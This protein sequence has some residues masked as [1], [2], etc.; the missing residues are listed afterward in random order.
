MRGIR[1]VPLA[2]RLRGHLFKPMRWHWRGPW[3]AAR[4]KVRL[5]ASSIVKGE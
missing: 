4:L 5:R 2:V 1:H 3:R